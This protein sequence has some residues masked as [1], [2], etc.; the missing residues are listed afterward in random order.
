MVGGWAI[1]VIENIVE[2]LVM[3]LP[4]ILFRLMEFPRSKPEGT[5]EG[6]GVYLTVYP[7]VQCVQQGAECKQSVSGQ[8]CQ[9]PF[10]YILQVAV[11]TIQRIWISRL[12]RYFMVYPKLSIL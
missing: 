9:K 12:G 5:P 8:Y 4:T 1:T 7:S 2:L 11:H 6:E 10:V 3:G